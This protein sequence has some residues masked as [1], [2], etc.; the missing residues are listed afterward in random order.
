MYDTEL[1][2]SP[3]TP[4]SKPSKRVQMSL[5]RNWE[6][7]TVISSGTLVNRPKNAHLEREESLPFSLEL[8]RRPP[9][10]TQAK[11]QTTG[12]AMRHRPTK[13]RNELTH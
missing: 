12:V 13:P 8:L 9:L 3:M 5:E 7:G 1:S 2:P 10:P 11:S 4:E 6:L